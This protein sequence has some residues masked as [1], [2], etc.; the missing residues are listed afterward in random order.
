[1]KLDDETLESL[2]AEV[3]GRLLEGD[4]IVVCGP[5]GLEATITSL[6]S[7]HRILSET[8]SERFL[9]DTRRLAQ[10]K[11]PYQSAR[12]LT[13]ALLKGTSLSALA[14]ASG[15][16]ADSSGNLADVSGNL[17]GA[18]DALAGCIHAFLPAGR[19][20]FLT[21]L[22]KMA[23]ASQIGLRLDLR[24]VPVFQQTIEIA[25]ITGKDPYMQ[26]SHGCVL[27]GTSHAEMLISALK[28]EGIPAAAAG[29]AVRGNDRLL[30]SGDIVRFLDRPPR[31]YRT[32]T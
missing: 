12:E 7:D 14:G 25:E 28:K 16:L 8:L 23:E 13:E 6:D 4:A 19:G 29:F 26:D 31:E 21:A 24:K 17:A 22:W 3:E 18:S 30:Y 27:V 1:M 11:A 2:R 10:H 20:G 9:S 15:T 5:V 32:L